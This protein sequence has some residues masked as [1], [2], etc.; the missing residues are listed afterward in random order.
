MKK[1]ELWDLLRSES[2]D[3]EAVMDPFERKRTGS[4]YTDFSFT[5][6]MMEELV[7][8]IR[9]GNKEIFDYKFLEPCVGVGNFVFSYLKVIDSQWDLTSKEAEILLDNI[10]VADINDSALESYKSSMREF[11]S[12]YWNMELTEA[13]FKKHVGSGLLV[14]VTANELGYIP[15]EAVFSEEI[16][17]EKFD[18]VVTNPPYKNLKAERGHY[19]SREEYEKDREKY[20]S[21]S[22]FVSGKFQYA[23]G[24]VLNLYRLFVEEIIDRYANDHAFVSLLVPASIMSDKTCGKLRTHILQD[25]NLL[26]AK[27]IRE[28]SGYVD[29]RQALCAVLLKKGGKTS[30]VRVAKDYCKNPSGETEIAVE[31]I[32]NKNT[33]DA[34]VAV[35]GREY[36]A[37]KKLRQFPSVKDL[38]FIINLRGELDLTANKNSIVKENTGYPLLRGRNIGY[39][40]LADTAKSEY[41]L[42]EFVNTTKKR[43]YVEKERIICQ[44]IA[45]MHKERRVTFALTPANYVLGNSCNFIFVE[46]NPYGVDLYAILGLFNTKL[47]N[48]LFKLTSSNNHVNN[49]EIDCFPVPFH[50]PFL[51]EISEKV[52]S[53]LATKEES[54][55]DDIEL[56]AKKA[57]GIADDFGAESA[58]DTG[59]EVTDHSGIWK[60]YYD[61]LHCILPDFTAED[62]K[63]VLSG[64]KVISGY[65]G[66]LDKLHACAA[67]GI[68]NKYTSLSN[69]F[70]LNHTTFKLSDLDLEMIKSVPPGGSWKDI[71]AKTVEK[72]KRLK[73]IAQTGGRTTL[74]GRID[75][76]KPSYTITTY[77]NR[78]GN[79]TYVHPVHERVISVREAARFQTFQDDYYFYGN[80][81]Q[82]LKQVGNAVPV[83]LAYQIG[84]AIAE[85][86]GCSKSID[87]FCGAG[88]LT[89]GFKEAGITSLLS[90]DM[91][92]SACVTLKINHPEIPVFCG[93]ITKRETKDVIEKAAKDGGAEIICGGPPCQGFSMAGFRSETDPRNQLF[94]EFADIVKRVNPKVIVFENV[95]GLLSYQGGKIYQEVH[96][97]FAELGY[98]T[99]GRSLMA[100]DY[101]V[102]QKRKRVFIICTRTDL[103]IF[104]GELYPNT[105]TV[106]EKRQITARE[107]IADLETVACS[108]TAKYAEGS[109]SRI[110]K[111]FKG[112]ISYEEYVE[113]YIESKR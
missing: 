27:V 14:D 43:R 72:S 50:S 97:L 108:D 77:F 58:Y 2:R 90:N 30:V 18:I 56:L 32:L 28:G 106:Q 111:F 34:I 99:E 63:A 54:I 37:L 57:F 87:L 91:E 40:G 65:C 38:D 93:D 13:Y 76:D 109:E 5:D 80:K 42:P 88:G 15:M 25:M 3:I 62:A 71:P 39:Y 60:Q 59:A 35:S 44:Q 92:E 96:A 69:G 67:K 23:A 104:P 45:N 103:N 47:I 85:K 101:A 51:K 110:L 89:T 83:L 11:A 94:R 12:V 70:I 79:G 24:G 4:Y 48:W 75:Y 95:E 82:L 107:T 74:Y 66:S 8:F 22:E 84:K 53:Y 49:Y 52:K 21:I 102:P 55:L 10:Y 9:K 33:G 100:N 1:D 64:E 29:A 19:R 98:H 31:D 20:S 113:K 105:I 17:R 41:A 81:T 46:E 112:K 68:T 78:P 6:I 36:A 73:K 16:S 26:S 86:T 7:S 61:D